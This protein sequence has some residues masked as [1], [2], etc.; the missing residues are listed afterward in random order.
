MATEH[1]PGSAAV[2]QVARGLT[3]GSF[4]DLSGYARGFDGLV[5]NQLRA[6]ADVAG[7]GEST[8]TD[9]RGFLP[10]RASFPIDINTVTAPLFWLPSPNELYRFRHFPEGTATGKPMWTWVALLSVRQSWTRGPS[11]LGRFFVEM[12]VSGEIDRSGAAP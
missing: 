7:G 10:G 1:T 9:N 12:R 4:V 3:G 5:A 2:T 8:G 6:Q 11:G